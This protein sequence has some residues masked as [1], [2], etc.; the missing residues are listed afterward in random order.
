MSKQERRAL[1]N[2]KLSI[3]QN[4]KLVER[5]LAHSGTRPDLAVVYSAAKYYQTLKKLAKE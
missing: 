2:L 3:K 4:T 5:K 1:Q